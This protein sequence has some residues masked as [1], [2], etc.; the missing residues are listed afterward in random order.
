MANLIDLDT[1]KT[2]ERIES[3][4]DDARI[5]LLITS[6]SQLVKTYCGTTIIDHYST[7]KAE[8]FTISWGTNLAQLTES[9]FVSITTVQ[10]RSD[11]AAAYTTVPATEYYVDASTDTVYRVNTSGSAKEWPRGPA[12]V[13]ITYKAGYENCPADLE[14][15]VIDL[16]TYYV[17]DEHKARQTMQGASIQNNTSS[18][19]SNNIAFPDHIKR[20]LDLYK[21]F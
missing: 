2:S 13:K 4:K 19:Q 7:D 5:S 17:K 8:E 10:E 14:L 9:P 20:V 12:S 21:N 16:I 3:T 11:F 6:V 1:Y 15:A 18:S